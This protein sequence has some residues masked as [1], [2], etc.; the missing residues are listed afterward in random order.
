M[1]QLKKIFATML[2]LCM[3]MGLCA[4]GNGAGDSEKSSGNDTENNQIENSQNA[5][6]E[7]ESQ[8]DGKVEYTV[9]VVDESG[10]PIAGALVQMCSNTCF[11]SATDANGVAT[12]NLPEAEYKVSFLNTEVPA[13][14]YT[15]V[16][17]ET[18]FYFDGDATELTITLK[19]AQ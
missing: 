1:K 11:P 4:C 9:K 7:T 14:G 18:N 10:N 2:M 17:E 12:F 8:D 16:G 3:V 19:A 15:Y 5:S 13:T 6:S